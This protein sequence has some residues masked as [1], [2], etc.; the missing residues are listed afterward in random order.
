MRSTTRCASH[1]RGF[2]FPVAAV[3]WLER[4]E[5]LLEDFEAKVFEVNAT[6]IAAPKTD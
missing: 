1:R 3:A 4:C 5:S 2:Y 6:D